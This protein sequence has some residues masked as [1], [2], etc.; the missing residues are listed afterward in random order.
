ML[1]FHSRNTATTWPRSFGL[2]L[3]MF[4]TPTR[5][6]S[7]QVSVSSLLHTIFPFHAFDVSVLLRNKLRNERFVSDT[8]TRQMTGVTTLQLNAGDRVQVNRL[9]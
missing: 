1:S 8:A 2:L 4:S 6:T 7:I 9:I 5:G 3:M